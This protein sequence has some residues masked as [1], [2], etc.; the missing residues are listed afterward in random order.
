VIAAYRSECSFESF[1]LRLQQ[2][3]PDIVLETAAPFT[4]VETQ[5]QKWLEMEKITSTPDWWTDCKLW[6]DGLPDYQWNH[7][8]INA[9]LL[10]NAYVDEKSPPRKLACEDIKACIEALVVRSNR[11]GRLSA[12]EFDNLE[13]MANELSPEWTSH[14]L[15]TLLSVS[16]IAAINFIG[17]FFDRGM[18]DRNND[19]PQRYKIGAGLYELLRAYRN[20]K[21]QEAGA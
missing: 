2:A 3:Q 12:E 18:I 14:E 13:R 8:F 7:P 19:Q 5:Y 4:D 11:F 6:R 1:N 21:T 20:L 15:G 16:S 10:A 9:H 17:S